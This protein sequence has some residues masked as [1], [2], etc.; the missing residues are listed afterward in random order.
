[1]VEGMKMAGIFGKSGKFLSNVLKE[2]KRV[3]WPTKRE[4]YRYTVTVTLTV[5]FVSVFFALID[6]GVT[7]LIRVLFE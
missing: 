1:V 6:L 3:S 4:L 5:I 2:L 7:K